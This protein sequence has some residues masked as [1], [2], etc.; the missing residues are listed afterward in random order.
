[1]VKKVLSN[2]ICPKTVSQF[3]DFSLKKYFPSMIYFLIM[4]LSQ[5]KKNEV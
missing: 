4:S 3:T 5:G 1:M 2:A